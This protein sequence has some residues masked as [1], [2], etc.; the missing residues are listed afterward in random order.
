MPGII[1]HSRILKEAVRYLSQKD[2]KSYL[3]NSIAALFNTPDH[4]TAGL[5]GAIGPNIF[6]YLPRRSKNAYYGSDISF[7]LHNGGSNKL[8]QAM[9]RKL[10]GYE[11]KNNEWASIQRAYLYGY[12]SHIIADSLFHPF[13]FYYSGF[14]SAYTKK[15][16]RFYREQNLLFQY[17][18]DSYL[19]YHAERSEL[20]PFS[21]DE[22][23]PVKKRRGLYHLDA[24]VKAIVLEPLQEVYPEIYE[25]LLFPIAR[26]ALKK[27]SHLPG[28]LD[29]LPYCI[30]M[31]YRLK[32]GTNRRIADLVLSVRRSNLFYSD[33]IIRYPIGRKYNK[34]ILNLNREQWEN[35]AG[36]SGRHYESIYNLLAISCEKTV[37]AWEAIE[38]TLYV[39]KKLNIPDAITCN[40][41][42]GDAQLSYHDMK[43]KRPIRLS[44]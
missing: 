4:L 38:S 33:F 39:K 17:H 2:K 35:P 9:I 24:P 8:L 31:T 29:I 1:T 16:I 41:Y 42:T 12:I 40:A 19:Q 5:F 6:D 37:E 43:A 34:N 15:E 20:F 10:H 25:T 26:N 32:R 13:V 27:Y 3:L 11:D 21:V 14:P 36:K 28:A 22:M 30:L 44:F 23:L 7:F 18:I